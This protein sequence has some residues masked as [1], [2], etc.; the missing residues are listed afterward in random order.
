MCV[1]YALEVIITNRS[2]D[3]EL[4]QVLYGG[5]QLNYEYFGNLEY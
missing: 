2:M 4:Q 3:N 5:L 1:Y